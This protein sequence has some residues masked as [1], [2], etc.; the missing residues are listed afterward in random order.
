M[1]LW[2]SWEKCYQG[3]PGRAGQQLIPSHCWPPNNSL[4][5]IIPPAFYPQSH[6][7]SLQ[8]ASFFMSTLGLQTRHCNPLPAQHDDRVLSSSRHRLLKKFQGDKQKICE[9]WEEACAHLSVL[10]S[11]SLDYDTAR[12]LLFVYYFKMSMKL[13]LAVNTELSLHFLN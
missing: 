9:K 8:R 10:S 4:S 7:A 3:R 2:Q 12:N 11:Q 5:L 1:C 13:H 6:D